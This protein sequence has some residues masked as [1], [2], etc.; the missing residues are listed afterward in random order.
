MDEF[1]IKERVGK[2]SFG[3]VFSA[4]HLP[5]QKIVAIKSIELEDTT[6]MDEIRQEIHALASLRSEWIT[7]YYSSFVNSSALYIV[8]EFCDGGS[9]SDLLKGGVRFNESEVSCLVFQILSGLDYIHQM[10]RI[11]RDIKAANVLLTGQGRVKLADFG[12][13]G[14]ITSTITKKTTFVGTPYWM[15]PEVILRSAYNTKADIWSLGITIW[16]FLHGLPPYANLHP[17]KVLF[18]IPKN[19]PPVLEGAYSSE[20]QDFVSIC[21][22]KKASSVNLSNWRE[23]KRANY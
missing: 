7:K 2:G 9:C 16:E 8:M 18:I 11:H 19:D 17:M 20:I 22:S 14:Q 5:T 12:V 15:A 10:G 21:L 4:I 1:Q 23:C 13:S 6:D 3:K